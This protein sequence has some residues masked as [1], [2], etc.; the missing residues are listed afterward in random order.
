MDGWGAKRTR[1]L[2][3]TATKGAKRMTTEEYLMTPETVLPQELIYGVFR[4]ADA[5]TPRHQSAVGDFYLALTSHVRERLI[6][7]VWLSPID[8]ILDEARALVLQP[9]LL[10]ISNERRHIL[11]DRIHGAPDMVLEVLSPHPRIGRLGERVGW[12]AKH[13]VLECWLLHQSKRRLEVVSFGDG[14]VSARV[15]FD[16]RAPI[17]SAV[18]PEFRQ[19][20][21]SILR[22]TLW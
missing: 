1:T 14:A 13:G 22:P 4:A 15:S 20:L 18:L 3:K 9:D 7:D 2:K 19:N 8:V 10:F 6:G 21:A 5:P 12:F 11:T 16:E 17:R